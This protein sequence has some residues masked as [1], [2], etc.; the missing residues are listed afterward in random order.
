MIFFK[1]SPLN[2]SVA[3]TNFQ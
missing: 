1:L 3:V 2:V